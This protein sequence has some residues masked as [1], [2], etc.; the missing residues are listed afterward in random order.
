MSAVLGKPAVTIA[1]CAHYKGA[2]VRCAAGVD[3]EKLRDEEFRLPCV[4]VGGKTGAVQCDELELPNREGP[5]VLG[6]A[7]RA[8]ELAE[9]GCCTTCGEKVE[10]EMKVGEV[11]TAQPCGHKLRMP[12]RWRR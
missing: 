8:L 12:G 7:T 10:R 2:L 1:T 6:R 11:I 4:V 3:V 9:S 5:A